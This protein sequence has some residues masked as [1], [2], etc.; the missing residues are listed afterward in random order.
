MLQLTVDSVSLQVQ[1]R[2]RSVAELQITGASVTFTRRPQDTGLTLSVHGLLLVDALQTYGPDFELLV[3][4][5]RHVGMDS[6][7]G[8]L[9]DSEPTSPISPASPDPA[10]GLRRAT[11]PVALSKALSGLATSPVFGLAHGK[12]LK[13]YNNIFYYVLYE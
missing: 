12:F 7:S 1:S 2:G 6:V 11:S 13:N 8:S 10:L 3:A 5:H 9:R 4:S